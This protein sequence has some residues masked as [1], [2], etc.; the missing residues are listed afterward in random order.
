MLPKLAQ[1]LR[2]CASAGDRALILAPQR[3]DYIVAFL[4]A[5]QAGLIAVPLLVPL[6]GASDQ[7]VVSVLHD[8][9]LRASCSSSAAS[10]I[11]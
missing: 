5:L 6:G 10:K 2:L 8:A 1:E 4:G 7:R 9:S 3:V 11:C